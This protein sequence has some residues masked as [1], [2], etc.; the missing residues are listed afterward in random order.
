MRSI[1]VS[2]HVGS[3]TGYAIGP[4]EL[5]FYRMALNL[6]GGDAS[7]V[8]F[9]YP[10]MANG[11]SST[12]PESFDR[13]LVADMKSTDRNE[14]A[15]AAEYVR[16][17]GIDTVFGFD[18]GVARPVY[19][20]LR[21]AGVRHMISYWGAPMSS[22]NTG[23]KR[24]LKQLSVALSRHG[25]DHYVFESRGMAETAVLG[26]GIPAGRT[27]VIY[28]GV[29]IGRFRPDPAD[30]RKVY[31]R[32]SIPEQR[33][34]FFYSGHMEPR[35]G[36]A[37]IM[38]AAN[39]VAGRRERD[40]WH[41]LLVGNKAD[42]HLPHVALL[43]EQARGR[44][45]FGGYRSDLDVLQRGCYAAVIASTGWDSFPRS[46]ME[47]QAS[48][49]PVL[50]S[51]LRGLRES[52]EDNGTGLLFP[53]GDADALAN[54]MERL[55]D[56]PRLRDRLAARARARIEEAFTEDIQLDNL[57]KLVARLVASA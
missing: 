51:D 45:T 19:P 53:T 40:D 54:A 16:Q 28:L 52:I 47:M 44:V 22:V 30:A 3:N 9:A 23:L 34:L 31:E 11:P 12:L 13:Y 36:V 20:A 56:E 29:D 39:R 49:L 32:L 10:S 57:T 2:L 6:T 15:R 25:P 43:T 27:S 21:R 55:L 7:R 41:I 1:L 50:V 48:G 33:R 24:L 42:E 5:L 8:H 37:V 35:K 17:H 18:L 38:Q 14:H 4:L 46:G 26:R